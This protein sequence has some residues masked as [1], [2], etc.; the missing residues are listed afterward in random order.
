MH[1]CLG[2]PHCYSH[3]FSP[4]VFGNDTFLLGLHECHFSIFFIVKNL[5]VTCVRP[6]F[7]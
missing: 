5:D 3:R 7:C 6:T 4:N 1:S 2:L